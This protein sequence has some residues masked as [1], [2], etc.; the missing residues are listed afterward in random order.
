MD[1]K[2][3]EG[4]GSQK[5]LTTFPKSSPANPPETVKIPSG[6]RELFKDFNIKEVGTSYSTGTKHK[7]KVTELLIMN[8]LNNP[9]IR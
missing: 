5:G 7:K 8:Y 2:A 1:E 9:V 6:I 4:W 3:R